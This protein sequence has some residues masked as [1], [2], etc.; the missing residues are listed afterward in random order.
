MPP[1]AQSEASLPSSETPPVPP[2]HPPLLMNHLLATRRFYAFPSIVYLRRS[3]PSHISLL[4]GVI[5][6]LTGAS[7]SCLASD[8]C[9]CFPQTSRFFFQLLLLWWALSGR[10]E[11][12]FD[13]HLLYP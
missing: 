7:G 5:A 12:P 6:L 10:K 9:C 2:T 8:I 13:S 3:S 4:V 11:R 1:A